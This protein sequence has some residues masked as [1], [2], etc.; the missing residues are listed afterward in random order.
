MKINLRKA[1]ALQAEINNVIS[2]TIP[3]KTVE[4]NQYE[5]IQEQINASENAFDKSLQ[6][7]NG[8]LT[9]LF[10]IRKKVSASNHE[11]GVDNILCDIAQI[12]RQLSLYES[13]TNNPMVRDSDKV[14]EGKI[15]R[16]RKSE[17]TD[18]YQQDSIQTGILTPDKKEGMK[19]VV[20]SLKKQKKSLEDK[21]L[22]LNVSSYIELSKE[23]VDLLQ[24]ESLI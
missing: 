2:K 7:C 12:S 8:L 4:L 21:L 16:I 3:Q 24:S 20:N 9:S 11:N 13:V 19:V 1:S 17:S 22:E 15:E 14:L 10:E 5:E 18:F 23:T 6:L